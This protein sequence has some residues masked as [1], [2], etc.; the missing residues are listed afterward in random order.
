[1]MWLRAKTDGM[2]SLY[3]DDGHSFGYRGDDWM[4]IQ[5][6]WADGERRLTLRLAP[7]SPVRPPA[8]RTFEVRVAGSTGT[9][10]VAF[11]GRP[12]EIRL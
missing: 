9:R 7:G 5:M 10:T 4:K 11:E 6:V 1:M 12:V 8:T 3:E 2:S